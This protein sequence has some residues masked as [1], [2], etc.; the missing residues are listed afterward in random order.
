MISLYIDLFF[1]FSFFFFFF[2]DAPTKFEEVSTGE[3][4]KILSENGISYNKKWNF[5]SLS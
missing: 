1:F 4:E 3:A 5:M 2:G